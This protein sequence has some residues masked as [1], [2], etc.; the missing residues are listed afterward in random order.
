M[1]W[2]SC[3]YAGNFMCGLYDSFHLSFLQPKFKYV[4]NGR[5]NHDS[6][7][8][9]S[10]PFAA[11]DVPG[12]LRW[13]TAS[14]GEEMRVI[15]SPYQVSSF[16][17]S[18]GLALGLLRPIGSLFAPW[19]IP[20]AGSQIQEDYIFAPTFRPLL[21]YLMSCNYGQKSITIRYLGL[22]CALSMRSVLGPLK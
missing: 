19:A 12:V 16:G 7:R 2:G 22:R 5:W 10:C 6:I 20:R 15:P 21:Y 18:L 13:R 11:P 8:L 17:I 4:S 9:L 3:W 14:R 1:F